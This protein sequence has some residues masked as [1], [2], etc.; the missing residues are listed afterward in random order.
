MSD[1]EEDD[2]ESP[3][4]PEWVVTFG[5]MMSLL[6][7]F[8]IMIYSLSEIKEPEK[9]TVVVES[10]RRQ[11]GHEKTTK[12]PAPGKHAPKNSR[13]K[14]VASMGRA[15]RLDLMRGGNETQAPLGSDR[16]ETAL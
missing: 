12:N 2:D 14:R 13:V 7:T 11:F 8:F 1:Q 9:F 10:L 5:D 4:I 6:L 15:K 16:R 3:G